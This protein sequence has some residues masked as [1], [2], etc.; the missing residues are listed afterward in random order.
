[1]TTRKATKKRMMTTRK[2]KRANCMFKL[3]WVASDGAILATE[4][5]SVA[6]SPY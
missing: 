5:I 2:K 3:G 1:M 6:R 4:I